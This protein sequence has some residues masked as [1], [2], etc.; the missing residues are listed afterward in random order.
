MINGFGGFHVWFE[1]C[2]DVI[3]HNIII[4]KEPYQFIRANPHYAKTFDYNLFFWEDGNPMI[5]GY[6]D[7]MT[8]EQWQRLRFDQHSIVADPMFVDPDT[9]D[10]RVKPGSPALLLGFQNFQMDN[11]GV[12]K[13]EYIQEV[14][15]VERTFATPEKIIKWQESERSPEPVSWLGATVKNLIGEAEKSAAGIA[16]FPSICTFKIPR[17]PS[18]LLIPKAAP[19]LLSATT[20]PASWFLSPGSGTASIIFSCLPC[21]MV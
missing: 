2:G 13:P 19:S 18:P 16:R 1:D 17:T 15:Q 5:T 12:Y 14:S 10:Y 6:K 11:F 3:A 9:G 4:N 20:L 8:I 7:D 21:H